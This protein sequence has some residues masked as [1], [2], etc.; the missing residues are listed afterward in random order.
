MAE[1]TSERLVVA[2]TPERCF[3][4]VADVERYP[5]WVADIKEV[6]VESR[7]GEGRPETVT[8][9]A[10]AFGRSTTYTLTYDY[11]G[12]PGSIRWVLKQGDLTARLDGAYRFSPHGELSTEVEYEL[13]VE[14]RVPIP[15][16]V[17]R[18][19]EGHI[20][21]A[22]IKELRERVETSG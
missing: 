14:L 9:R 3:A 4:V 19:A 6:H 17:K 15:G 18:R 7:D 2:A 12:A 21:H 13:M 16:F 22:A 20:L 5:E 11:T 10:A 8:F 1:H